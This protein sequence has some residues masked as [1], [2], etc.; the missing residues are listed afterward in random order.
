MSDSTS[1][2][3]RSGTPSR[4]STTRAS[5]RIASW[6]Y[7]QLNRVL[8]GLDLR[9]TQVGLK[10][11]SRDVSD[12]VIPLLLV[13]RF[14][15]DL[16]LLAVSNAL[17][18]DRVR[19]MP[20]RLEYRF[21]GSEV[22]SLAALRTLWD[23]AAIFYR[24]RILRTYRRRRALIVPTRAPVPPVTILGDPEVAPTLDYPALEV[25]AGDD[26]TRLAAAAHG[27]L[28]A[29]LEPGARP[30]GNWISAATPYF[31]RPEIAAVVVPELAPTTSSVAEC[32]AAAVLE[33]RLGG[34]SRRFRYL[35]GNVRVTRDHPAANVIVRATD[36]RDAVAADVD[37]EHLVAWLSDRERQTVY[38]PD[39]SISSV[40]APVFAPHLQATATHACAR[41]SA[42]R[43]T[44]GRSVSGATAFS[45]VPAILA[46]V[47]L[48][49]LALGSRS[50]GAVLLLVY[51]A[52]VAGSTVFAGLRFRSLSVALLTAPALVA[53][54]A[55][56][57]WG[58]ATGV[59]RGR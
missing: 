25:V 5:R 21:T 36:Y 16:E 39:T 48:V 33:S 6:C 56:Y 40:P 42:A 51:A 27:E 52:T 41:G 20:V 55:A 38:T 46:V 23:T 50:G 2:S 53:T 47:G 57:V 14:A 8:F 26:P 3:A 24:L 59:V 11:F 15:F 54:H 19:E 22:T 17:G 1:S 30:A 9:D 13:K 35:P 44:R 58:F 43:R 34:G 32:A 29:M 45:L 7:Q 49:V 18:H 37:S 31:T 28:L 4:W 12:N 10:V